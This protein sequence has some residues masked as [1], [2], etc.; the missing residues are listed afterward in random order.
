METPVEEEPMMV[1]AAADTEEVTDRTL[2]APRAQD[3]HDTRPA[4]WRLLSALPSACARCGSSGQGKHPMLQ[5][6]CCGESYH[7]FCLGLPAD[8]QIDEK[9]WR[10]ADCNVCVV[11]G[12]GHDDE[13]LLLC[14]CGKA[15]HTFCLRPALKAVPTGEWKCPSCVRCERCGTTKPG[16]GGWKLD[17]RFCDKCGDLHEEQGY[18]KICLADC[19]EEL[20]DRKYVCCEAPLQP[21]MPQCGF[22]IHIECDHISERGY[23]FLTTKGDKIPYTCP[24]CRG[25]APGLFGRR[26]EAMLPKLPAPK[27]A[28]PLAPWGGETAPSCASCDGFGSASQA[29]EG[30]ADSVALGRPPPPKK[31]SSAPEGADAPKR[32]PKRKRCGTCSACQSDECGTCSACLD[33][34]KFGGEGK[35]KQ[36][37]KVRKCMNMQPPSEPKQTMV[38]RMEP[39]L[40]PESGASMIGNG[41]QQGLLPAEPRPQAQRQPQAQQQQ[42]QQQ[43]QQQM[44]PRTHACNGVDPDV[45]APVAAAAAKTTVGAATAEAAAEA[46]ATHAQQM[47][48]MQ[49][50]QMQQYYHSMQMQQM[51]GFG[52]PVAGT[53]TAAAGFRRAVSKA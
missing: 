19:R 49:Q 33:M 9:R 51:M 39:Q 7:R 48:R 17:Y 50:M 24:T 30:A 25:E 27:T 45:A 23:E 10:C 16:R 2:T 1:G 52:G 12:Q 32:A 40:A 13:N 42:Q 22:W 44:P 29:Q 41:L 28:K 15:Y 5:C 8:V 26:I 47:Q 21:H 46:A 43:P 4:E 35:K 11:C 53:G 18:C 3:A 36:M 6:I 34:L 20:G 31:G 38:C 14:E 37:C